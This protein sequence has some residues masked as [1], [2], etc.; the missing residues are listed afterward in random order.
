MFSKVRGILKKHVKIGKDIPYGGNLIKVL[1][2][3]QSY[4][5]GSI[6][7]RSLYRSVGVKLEVIYPT[8]SSMSIEL[9]LFNLILDISFSNFID[10]TENWIHKTFHRTRKCADCNTEF[11][12]DNRHEYRCE[13][14]DDVYFEV[15][16]KEEHAERHKGD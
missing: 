15:L 2:G 7:L 13:P 3:T 9:Q 6:Q 4:P 12:S 16:T 10:K 11:Y 5:L 14:C 8:C 1:I